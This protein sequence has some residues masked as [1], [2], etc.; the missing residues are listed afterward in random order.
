MANANLSL[1]LLP[2]KLCGQGRYSQKNSQMICRESF[3]RVQRLT[4]LYCKLPPASY[5]GR[6]TC[7]HTQNLSTELQFG[8]VFVLL[9]EVLEM[10]LFILVIKR[11][12]V[13][14]LGLNLFIKAPTVFKRKLVSSITSCFALWG[15][16]K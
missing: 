7:K 6:H 2:L 12:I 15:K 14:L 10:L 13:L 11:N 16:K 4:H 8:T 5:P 9:L 1:N 3:R